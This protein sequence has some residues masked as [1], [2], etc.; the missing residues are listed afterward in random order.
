METNR[1][2]KVFHAIYTK[3][4]SAIDSME[5]HP[6]SG[7]SGKRQRTHVKR[8]IDSSVQQN[9]ISK[10]DMVMIKQIRH[11]IEIDMLGKNHTYSREKRFIVAASILGW[12]IHKN[13]KDLTETK[14]QIVKPPLTVLYVGNG[15]EAYSTNIFIPAKSELTSHDPKLTR[16]TFFLDFNEEYQDLTK[17]SMIQDLHFEQLTPEERESLP[18][19]LTALPPLQF[20]HLKK[21]IKPLP[22]TKPPFKI[23]PNIVLIMLLITIVLVVL[24]L[25]FLVWCIYKVQSRVKGFKPMAK[26]F[27]GNMDN[28]EESVTQLLSLIKN[29]V[30][31]MTKSLLSASLTDLPHSSGMPPCPIRRPQPPPRQDTLPPEEIELIAQVAASQQTLHEVAQELKQKEPKTYKGYIKQL[32]R[33]AEKTKEEDE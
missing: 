13:K 23:H 9:N 21:R 4:I 17:Y 12:K 6:T 31:H 15:C 10:D 11:M 32:K 2:T 27:T 24:F 3:F 19:R 25:G 29:P 20:N 5:N 14:I 18:G 28:L 1:I 7:K 30:G 26:L 22:I 8:N 33:K 16:H